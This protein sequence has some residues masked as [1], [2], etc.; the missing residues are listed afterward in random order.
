MIPT[1]GHS[2][3]EWLVIMFH[4]CLKINCTKFEKLSA[5]MEAFVTVKQPRFFISESLESWDANI[6][7]H[8][9]LK[10]YEAQAR[11]NR[12]TTKVADAA[13]DSDAWVGLS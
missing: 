5:P 4:V 13:F 3:Y 8:Y 7:L 9:V 2:S 11:I 1:K 6:E 12:A 10:I